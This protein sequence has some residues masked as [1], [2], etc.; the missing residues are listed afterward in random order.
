MA[1]RRE[2]SNRFVKLHELTIGDTFIDPKDPAPVW[3][4][5]DEG[6]VDV[7]DGLSGVFDQDHIFK[8]VDFEI[9][10]AGEYC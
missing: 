9:I 10:D 4:K 2:G 5:T 8:L 7:L 6:I 1:I 3:L